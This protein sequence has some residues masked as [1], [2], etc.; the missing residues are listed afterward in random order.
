MQ[1][2]ALNFSASYT[3][4]SLEGGINKFEIYEIKRKVLIGLLLLNALFCLIINPNV[5]GIA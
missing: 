5:R 1:I 3:R 4:V 2:N